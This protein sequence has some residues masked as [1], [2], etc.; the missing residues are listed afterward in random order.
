MKN[1]HGTFGANTE[2]PMHMK[3]A[4]WGSVELEGVW[5]HVAPSGQ[6]LGIESAIRLPNV[7]AGTLTT[8]AL[9]GLAAL[10]FGTGVALVASLLWALDGNAIAI[11]RIGKEDTFLLFFFILA[12]ACYVRARPQ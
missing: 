4:M 2:H 6:T 3:L 10:L 5:N 1:S 7:V 11:S 12:M 8:L 9:F